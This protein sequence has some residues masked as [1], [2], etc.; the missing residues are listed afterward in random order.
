MS[1]ITLF[2]IQG[3]TGRNSHDEDIAE[4]IFLRPGNNAIQRTINDFH[5]ITPFQVSDSIKYRTTKQYSSEDQ[6]SLCSCNDEVLGFTVTNGQNVKVRE[7]DT[8]TA[9]GVFKFGGNST[10]V[11]EITLKPGRELMCVVK[12]DALFLQD[13]SNTENFRELSA[14]FPG[15]SF[16]F[17]VWYKNNLSALGNDNSIYTWFSV[18]ASED[19][20]LRPEC[21]EGGTDQITCFA[22]WNDLLV[23]GTCKCE[24]R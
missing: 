6:V 17:A 24:K 4:V 18:S 15:I 14:P 9:L 5:D 8:P 2:F 1:H 21:I 10:S 16:S 23:Y 13:L 3:L 12:E 20:E 19:S 22:Y 7:T 11:K